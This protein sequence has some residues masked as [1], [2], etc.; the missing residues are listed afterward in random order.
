MEKANNNNK[1]E[2]YINKF[3]ESERKK[4][5]EFENEEA[6]TKSESKVSSHFK[7]KIGEGLNKQTS[8]KS[9]KQHNL[10]PLKKLSQT[11]SFIDKKRERTD[12]EH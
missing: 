2:Y 11:E 8:S 9:G 4:A 1:E 3:A 5:I 10:S 7:N 12:V 6:D